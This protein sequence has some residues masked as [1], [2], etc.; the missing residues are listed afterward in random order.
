MTLYL[1]VYN[2]LGP[3]SVS[4]GLRSHILDEKES[5][6]KEKCAKQTSSK[7]LTQEKWR[8]VHSK[9]KQFLY[10]H[11]CGFDEKIGFYHKVLH[12]AISNV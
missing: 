9:I 5:S 4:E 3:S 2:K 6:E 1:F 8:Q 12:K 10:P 11:A 7:S